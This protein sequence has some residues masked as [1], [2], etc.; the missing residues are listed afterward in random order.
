MIDRQKP[1]RTWRRA[2]ARAGVATTLFCAFE[3]CA[4]TFLRV[5]GSDADSTSGVTLAGEK[6]R[7]VGRTTKTTVTLAPE[8]TTD[9]IQP[10]PNLPNT[11]G[12]DLSR[13]SAA[14]AA[15]KSRGCVVCHKDA[16]DPHLQPD[17]P[18]TVQLGCIDCHGGDGHAT[19]KELAHVQPRY[20]DVWS[21]SA[22]PVRSYTVLNRESPE[23]IR[24]VN[25]GDLRIAHL[26]CGIC[27]AR[28]TLEVRKSMMT[29]GCML[30]GA[31]LYNNGAVPNK[32]ARYGE[33]YSMNGTPQRLQTVPAPTPEEI[34]TKGILP[35]LDPL[36]R[37]ENSQPGNIL[38]AFERGG[39]FLIES[40]IPE[41][42]EV[43]GRPRQRLSNRGLGTLNRTDPVFV[44]LQK[45]RLL[46]PTLNF[47]G[48]NDHAGDYRSSGCTSC[49][50]IYA[51]DRSRVNSGPW[52]K[53]GN[54]GLA[55]STVDEMVRS[56]DPTIPKNE[57]GHPVTHRFVTGV[58]TSQC[59]VCHV[60][61]GTNVMN[62]YLGFMWWDQET[63]GEFMYP[64]TEREITS[65]EFVQS[66]MSDPNEIAA[67]AK[68]SDPQFLQA[69]SELNPTLRKSYFAD[70][71]GHGWVF[72]A[73]F[74][75]DLEGNYLDHFGNKIPDP[76][77]HQRQ[78]AI[79]QSL[80]TQK[81][82]RNTDELCRP[83][84]S[85]W[86]AGDR[87]GVREDAAGTAVRPGGRCCRHRALPGER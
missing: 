85:N 68:T 59:I 70:F 37:F 49:H 12:V 73:V 3:L 46:D 4:F 84:L 32:W 29:H 31:A 47:L 40:G 64:P 2:L 7:L 78:I 38:R 39:R 14:D 87:K 10:Y 24:F 8:E 80:E 69:V 35:F 20:P 28:E 6:V 15:A 27:H 13:Q 86:S 52:A 43:N 1:D 61:P 17:R 42:L 81:L 72:K 83:T 22:N 60:H 34:A 26:S 62:S 65:E 56:V 5:P 58:P 19:T 57:P 48:T 41:T 25:P 30:W 23:F 79:D 18:L 66:Q 21:S 53:Y 75:K 50:M 33:S 45:T 51:N 55:H 44:G 9:L 77:A 74:K 54:Q 16:C 67:R 71:H 76:S 36:P 63:D 82:H 11:P